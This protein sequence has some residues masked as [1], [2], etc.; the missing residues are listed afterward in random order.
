[1]RQ[2]HQHAIDRARERYGLTLTADDLGQIGADIRAKKSM[3]VARQD[4]GREIHVVRTGPHQQL[5]RVLWAPADGVV[6]TFLPLYCKLNPR[7]FEGA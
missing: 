4:N 2:R 5:A 7:R 3:I 6:V 1:M